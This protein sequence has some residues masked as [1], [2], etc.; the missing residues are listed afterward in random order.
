MPGKER[1]RMLGGSGLR[2]S[3]LLF[4][5]ESGDGDGDDDRFLFFGLERQGDSGVNGSK[6]TDFLTIR[7][8]LS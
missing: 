4:A 3:M 1:R 2:G 6:V 5:R 7:I 8:G